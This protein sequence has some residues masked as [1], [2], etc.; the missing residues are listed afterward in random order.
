MVYAATTFRYAFDYHQGD[1]YFCTGD[2]GW[3]TGHTYLTYGPTLNGATSIVFEGVPTYP[4]PSRWWD[5]V[6]KY[7][8]SIFYTA[9]TAIRALMKC[10]NA[11]VEKTS[12]ESLRVLGSVG[13]PINVE[14]W[15]WY[16]DVVGDQ[17]VDIVDT[18][19]QT[20]TGGHMILPLPGNTPMK[21]GSAT[22]PFF[23]ITPAL[24]DPM[25]HE[26]KSGVAEGLLCIKEPWPGQARSIFNDHARFEEVYYSIQ[27]YYTTGDGARRDAD[28]YYWLTGRVD[29]VL[30]VSGHRLG[31]SEIECAI[32][33]NP[34]VVESAV[35]GV[36]H[37]IKGEGI[38]AYVVFRPGVDITAKEIASVRETVRSV[39]GPLASPDHI[40][41]AHALPKTRSGKIMRRIL[42]K[43]AVNQT[44]DLGDISTLA[45]PHVVDELI[46]LRKVWVEKR[47]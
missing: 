45:D 15:N 8:V 47:T 31:T 12:R 43:I 5:I 13:E 27:G 28:G 40:H 7:K 37:D 14:A 36:P 19:W 24:L 29:D 9:P 10:G 30:N 16:Y 4:S 18:W 38:Y 1:V 23:G 42:R 34:H 26:E 39:I 22:L 11:P 44:E 6:D 21:P 17:H 2:V 35:V 32:N 41:P 46:E 33:T 3:I 20:E 25:T